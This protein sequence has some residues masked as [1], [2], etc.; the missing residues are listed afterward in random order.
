MLPL[1]SLLAFLLAAVSSLVEAKN[2]SLTH[3]SS[4]QSEKLLVLYT[5]K[6]CKILKVNMRSRW[7]EKL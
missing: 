3:D 7:N 6:V 1:M 5:V 2:S 4:V